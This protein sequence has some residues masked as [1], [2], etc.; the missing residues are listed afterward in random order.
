MEEV[1]IIHLTRFRCITCVGFLFVIAN[2]L[3]GCLSF[4]HREASKKNAYEDTQS[5][6]VEENSAVFLLLSDGD[7]DRIVKEGL[8]AEGDLADKT[9]DFVAFAFKMS[10]I[11]NG[12]G[13][14]TDFVVTNEIVFKYPDGRSIKRE[15]NPRDIYAVALFA[16]GKRPEYKADFGVGNMGKIL[17]EYFEKDIRMKY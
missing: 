15:F 6:L 8:I 4:S 13:I 10:K 14:K 1:T 2:V 16:K 5:L 3:F 9:S 12:L 7:A 11:L 17:S